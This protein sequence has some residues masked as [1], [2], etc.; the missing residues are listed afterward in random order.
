[1]ARNLGSQGKYAEAESLLRLALRTHLRSL[2]ERH[3]ET[4]L[5][6]ESLAS[7]LDAQGRYVDGEPL[8]RN[9][10]AIL[11]DVFGY[12]HTHSVSICR[13]LAL[14]LGAQ[15]RYDEA[16]TMEANAAR[17]FETVRHQMS[18]TGLDRASFTAEISPLPMLSALQARAER[19]T[20]HG[21]TGKRDSREAC[22]TISPRSALG[23]SPWMNGAARRTSSAG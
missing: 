18:G 23:P 5:S 12:G 11:H 14:N 16:E 15:G 10:L 1:M 17:G 9:A 13:S 20:K 6:Y 22:S 4:G 21:N 8:H 19:T 7:D 2:G 3:V